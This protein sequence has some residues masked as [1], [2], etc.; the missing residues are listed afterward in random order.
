VSC[1][2]DKKD[3]EMAKEDAEQVDPFAGEDEYNEEY[4]DTVISDGRYMTV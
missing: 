2:D 1:L 4:W 3:K